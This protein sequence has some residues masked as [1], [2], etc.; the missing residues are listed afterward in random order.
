[1]G[2]LVEDDMACYNPGRPAGLKNVFQPS[3]LRVSDPSLQLSPEKQQETG[4]EKKQQ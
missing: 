2:Y 4:P 1:M 3:V